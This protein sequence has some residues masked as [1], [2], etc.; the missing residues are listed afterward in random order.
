MKGALALLMALWAA[1]APAQKLDCSNQVTQADMNQCGY[2]DYQQA[3]DA[4]NDAYGWAVAQAR[5]MESYGQPGAEAALRSAQRAWITF[6]DLACEAEGLQA[7]GGSMQPMLISG[8]LTRL[9]WARHDDLLIFA[10]QQ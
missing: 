7:E 5:D 9:T 4:L 10:G 1:P 6:R 3:D 8:C 2:I